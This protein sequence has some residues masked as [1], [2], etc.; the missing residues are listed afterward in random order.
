[1]YIFICLDLHDISVMCNSKQLF[2]QWVARIKAIKHLNNNY[3]KPPRNNKQQT[4]QHFHSQ[5]KYILIPK[6]KII[7]NKKSFQD[8]M[9]ICST[10]VFTIF[11]LISLVVGS[12]PH[13]R[14]CKG[15]RYYLIDNLVLNSII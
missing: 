10:I 8:P 7:K 3:I 15:G 9:R 5:R 1:M 6:P 13:P 12:F 4:N 11:S 14:A 2:S